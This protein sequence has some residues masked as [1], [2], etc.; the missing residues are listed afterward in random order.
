MLAF[1]ATTFIKPPNNLGLV[2]YWSMDEATSTIA[3]DFSGNGNVGTL[4]SAGGNLPQWVR[5][6]FGTA[7]QF[8]T[9]QTNYV[10]VPKL[11]NVINYSAITVSAWVMN[12]SAP[13][14][15][16]PRIIANSHTDVDNAGFQLIRTGNDS[17]G[18]CA[19]NVFAFNV[20]NG[21][22]NE[23]AY[24]NS[25]PTLNEW[26]HVVGTYDGV[27]AKVY[28]DGVAGANISG[29]TS[30]NIGLSAVDLSIGRNNSYSG[31][32]VTG[33]IDEVRLYRRALT[34]AE[35]MALYKQGA[36]RIQGS[37]KTTQRGSPLSTGLIGLWTFDGGD[38]NWTSTSA[39]VAY[40]GSGNNNIG[41][42]INMSQ[43]NS[44][45]AGTLGQALRFNGVTQYISEP[46]TISNIQSVAFWAKASTTA[47]IAQGLVNFTGSSIYI[48]TNASK[49]LSA[50]GF[51]SP[52]F[53]VD[54]SASSTPGLYDDA[55]HHVVVT[56]T[57]NI[58]GSQMEFA[59]ANG[60]YFG[61]S[62]DDVRVYDR[63]LSA[64]EAARLF[65]LGRT[66]IMP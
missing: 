58:T 18:V 36:V 5:G 4:S 21:S 3:G 52:T 66:V 49:V 22:T 50:T 25:T 2:A 24:L 40:D 45:I 55:W 1:A 13:G 57:A 62:L 38:L 61:G 60:V 28:V 37:S 44:P 29:N 16:N 48:S 39:G 14:S 59:R 10:N 35:V 23:C 65:L 11:N 20:G 42:L 30:G 7:L 31:D 41:T 6:K 46:T 33:Y 63:A 53:Y 15:T 17:G 8:D 54:G 51:T 27:D 26:H 9:A 43:N 56:G 64:S 32:Y 19:N 12:T 34:A 47:A